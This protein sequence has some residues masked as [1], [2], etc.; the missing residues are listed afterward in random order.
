MFH[1]HIVAHLTQFLKRE[2]V[3][4]VCLE[5]TPF[6]FMCM[7]LSI[8]VEELTIK[9]HGTDAIVMFYIQANQSLIGTP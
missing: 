3:S 1:C 7:M 4:F 9:R 6:I 5:T 2:D 8:Y